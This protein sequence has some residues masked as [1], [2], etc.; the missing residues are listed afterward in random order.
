MDFRLG[1]R[2]DIFRQEARAFLDEVLTDEVLDQMHRTGV[3]HNWDFHRALVE[4]GWLAPGWPEEFGGQ[5][6][7]PLEMLAFAEERRS[8]VSSAFC[9]EPL[10]I[11]MTS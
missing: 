3:H 10:S 7:D 4:R 8:S 5:G 11:R 1:E 2:S 6:R 9:V